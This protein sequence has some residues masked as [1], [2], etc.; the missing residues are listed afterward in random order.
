M[1]DKE[2]IK[3]LE[4]CFKTEMDCDGC[5]YDYP[6][7]CYLDVKRDAFDLIKRQQEEIDRL[8]ELFNQ[9]QE[10]I[11]DLEWT[12]SVSK[13]EAIKEFAERLKEKAKAE[14]ISSWD[15][16]LYTIEEIITTQ[17]VDNLVKEMV[18]A[19]NA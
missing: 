18:G 5:P 16:H 14:L 2:I 9:Q 6:D 7:V 10:I 11:A 13:A 3:A 19:D 8:K 4:H 1:T 17:Q 15:K 12:V